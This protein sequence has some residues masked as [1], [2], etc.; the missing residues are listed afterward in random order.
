MQQT[1]R[2]HKKVT[3]IETKNFTCTS[4]TFMW[5]QQNFTCRLRNLERVK[6][7][8]LDIMKFT[9]IRK[10]SLHA[11][12]ALKLAWM[13]QKR[14]HTARHQRRWT[15]HSRIYLKVGNCVIWPA[16]FPQAWSPH[17]APRSKVTYHRMHKHNSTIPFAFDT[18]RCVN[19]FQGPNICCKGAFLHTWGS[20][21]HS[22][23]ARLLAGILYP[24]A[25]FF[26]LASGVG[27]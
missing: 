27:I 5:R 18:F 11:G 25:I 4:F 16:T 26:V 17:G 24:V 12:F 7:L 14:N 2:L 19:T 3:I 1:R 23:V 22:I 21:M 9:K 15:H 20:F 10:F 6:Q 13:R 8:N